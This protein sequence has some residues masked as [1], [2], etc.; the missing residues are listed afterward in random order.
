MK[1]IS[2]GAQQKLEGNLLATQVRPKFNSRGSRKIQQ[3]ATSTPV[4]SKGEARF[5]PIPYMSSTFAGIQT[6][7]SEMNYR[8]WDLRAAA[9]HSSTILRQ[10]NKIELQS[11]K[12][13][14]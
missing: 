8:V 9:I 6:R 2:N 14:T 10:K 1:Q 11:N 7:I 3:F 4:R 13:F 12:I 5:A